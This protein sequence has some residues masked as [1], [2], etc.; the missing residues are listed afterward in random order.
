MVRDR[1][2]GR[3]VLGGPPVTSF[4]A[5]RRPLASSGQ[6]SQQAVV[7]GSGYQGDSMSAQPHSA[8]EGRR[9]ASRE[10]DAS[11]ALMGLSILLRSRGSWARHD[12]HTWA[13]PESL[14][15]HTL[16]WMT[17]VEA[18]RAEVFLGS[19]SVVFHRSQ[20]SP[21]PVSDPGPL[22][23]PIERAGVA[24]GVSR[25]PWFNP[26]CNGFLPSP[27]RSPEKRGISVK[28]HGN[29]DW[30]KASSR[31]CY[32][33]SVLQLSILGKQGQRVGLAQLHRLISSIISCPI[34][35]SGAQ[36][37]GCHSSLGMGQIER[38]SMSPIVDIVGFP[39]PDG[40]G[41]PV[42]RTEICWNSWRR[43]SSLMPDSG[44]QPLHESSAHAKHGNRRL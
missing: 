3:S 18:Q 25:P 29:D 27:S 9:G 7:S 23:L 21:R 24:A 13:P 40:A 10:C 14:D 39:F 44:L 17:M 41:I 8:A 19:F 42:V 43:A 32:K 15:Q 1:D 35:V 38:R 28:Q 5:A 34:A 2:R 6:L 16:L 36:L 4:A 11:P 33:P 22:P 31:W 37:K 20:V 12:T 26:A 30:S